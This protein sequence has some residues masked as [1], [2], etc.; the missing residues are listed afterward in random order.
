MKPR[1]SIKGLMV[2]VILVAIGIAALRSASE[3]WASFVLT[4]TFGL[5]ATAG[6]GALFS[7][8]ERQVFWIGFAAFGWGYVLVCFCTDVGQRM[9]TNPII[10]RF[11]AAHGPWKRVNFVIATPAAA[12]ALPS[13]PVPV[14]SVLAWESP[15]HQSF[16]R[17]GHSLFGLLAALLGGFVAR[18][19]AARNQ[20]VGESRPPSDPP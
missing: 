10:D 13:Q 20:E 16:R 9:V 11:Y 4:L 19:F 17:I 1:F 2:V 18:Y 3:L 7:R 15:Q 14:A 5:L 12:G 8:G 6:L